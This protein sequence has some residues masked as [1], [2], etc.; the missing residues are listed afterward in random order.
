MNIL[1][2]NTNE[3]KSKTI[4][5]T[6]TV[7]L[8]CLVV[9]FATYMSASFWGQLGSTTTA[10]ITFVLLGIFLELA[11]ICAGLSA[12]TAHVAKKRA[13]KINAILVLIIFTCVSFIASVGTIANEIKSGKTDAFD[14]D[15]Q[16]KFINNSIGAQE[17][18]IASLL[19]SQQ[20]DILHGYRAR[21]NATLAQVKHEQDQL[22]LL[23]EKLNDIEI[24][25]S[26]VSNVVLI[27]NSLIP[28]GQDQWE[29][30]LTVLLGA[31]TEITSLFLLFLN[32]SLKN[33][34]AV[35]GQTVAKSACTS[36]AVVDDLP[37]S[38]DEYRYITKQ[39]IAG[40]VVPTQRALK[41]VVKLG[42]EKIAKIFSKWVD[43]G[44]LIRKG[45][46][47]KRCA[48]VG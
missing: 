30:L 29:C 41:K 4:L 31:L 17:Q 40:K 38:S 21:A 20:N 13:L 24:N 27:F 26:T 42:N 6:L 25:D 47:Y 23:Q 48:A 8:T 14:N 46:S 18:V 32:F 22:A 16:V 2:L 36:S 12:I 33:I 7:L 37:I 45:R 1:Q 11:K 9:I 43:E 34:V 35:N 44:I 28:L 5:S 15:N 3:L 39:I 10:C 19:Q